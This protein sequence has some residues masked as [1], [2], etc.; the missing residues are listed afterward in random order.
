MKI[1]ITNCCGYIRFN[2]INYKIYINLYERLKIFY[3]KY[4]FN[5][6]FR[7]A[8]KAEVRYYLIKPPIRK[9]H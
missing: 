2:F 6:V 7:F 9:L 5:Y 1:L 4:F 3:K 8:A